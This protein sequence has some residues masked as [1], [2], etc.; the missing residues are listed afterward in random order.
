MT[1]KIFDFQAPEIEGLLRSRPHFA[2][3][4]GVPGVT[5]DYLARDKCR[6]DDPRICVHVFAGHGV[7]RSQ[8]RILQGSGSSLVVH[9][10]I[11]LP[12]NASP[13]RVAEAVQSLKWK[14]LAFPHGGDTPDNRAAHDLLEAGFREDDF[15]FNTAWL[16]PTGEEFVDIFVR[17]VPDPEFVDAG[18]HGQVAVETGGRI[19]DPDAPCEIGYA[20][21]ENDGMTSV[22]APDLRSALEVIELGLLPMPSRPGDHEV[23]AYADLG[24][25][26]GY[27]F[28]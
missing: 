18:V 27:R 4:C 16:K 6:K 9:A 23:F 20:H 1:L 3:W 17:D 5:L 15:F 14:L 8:A 25:A 13:D 21:R 24:P 19:A 2:E 11:P 10:K 28:A 12:A 7:N 26:S 22:I